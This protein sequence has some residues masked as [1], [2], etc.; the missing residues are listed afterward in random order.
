MN[1]S[2]RIIRDLN[3]D[4]PLRAFSAIVK[5]LVIM[6]LNIA[7]L[8]MC[9]RFYDIKLWLILTIYSLLFKVYKSISE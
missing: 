7:L 5:W 3:G 9:L 2:E 1:K 8:I 6:G 4:K